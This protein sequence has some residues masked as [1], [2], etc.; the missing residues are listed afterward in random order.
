MSN[1]VITR[2]RTVAGGR[3]A[4]GHLGEL[5]RIVGFDMVDAALAETGTVQARVRDLPS[6]VVVY[7][8]LAAGLFAEVGFGQVWQRMTA[9]L[10]GLPVPTP[11]DGALAQARRR[12]GPAPL[13]A[14]FA[15]LRGPAAGVATKGVYW[16]GLLVTAIDGT[17]MCCPDTAANLGVY[18]RTSG[19]R[20]GTGYPLVRL[21]AL[22]ACGTRTV[23]DATFGPASVGETTYTHD[24]IPALHR[25]M[26]VLACWSGSKT[27]APSRSAPACPTAPTSPAWAPS[28]SVSCA[29]RSPSRP[30]PGDAARWR[31]GG[32]W[33]AAG[34]SRSV[35]ARPRHPARNAR[36][37][38][39]RTAGLELEVRRGALSVRRVGRGA[40]AGRVLRRRR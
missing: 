12:I 23:I 4:P 11:T 15:L 27:P 19:Y 34:T 32:G 14:L 17:M 6:R 2:V 38:P 21:L 8:L 7:L 1:S 40:L 29:A 33:G 22:V 18:H 25:G 28:R 24:L 31:S 20:G 37:E 39:A 10:H 16:R 26:I 13:R 9:G 3:F 36:R 30:A 35:R 5:T